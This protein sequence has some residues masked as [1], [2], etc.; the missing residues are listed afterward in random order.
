M[1]QTRAMT[2]HRDLG[3]QS[4]STN[5]DLHNDVCADAGPNNSTNV[6]LQEDGE[7]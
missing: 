3:E 5:V 4:S 7:Q 2:V 1:V 6:E